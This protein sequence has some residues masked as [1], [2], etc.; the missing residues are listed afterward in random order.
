MEQE[1]ARSLADALSDI[2]AQRLDAIP[3]T[4]WRHWLVK[5]PELI[6]KVHDSNK[7][8]RVADGTAL[9]ITN[10]AANGYNIDLFLRALS[11]ELKAVG[12]KSEHYNSFRGFEP[13]NI[14]GNRFIVKRSPQGN[15]TISSGRLY[16]TEVASV[17]EAV[18]FIQREFTSGREPKP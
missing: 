6:A 7:R 11:L 5:Y 17:S 9:L 12:I 4:D 16:P 8:I 1:P 2:A 18:A 15:F 14:A 13:Q 3:E 10:H